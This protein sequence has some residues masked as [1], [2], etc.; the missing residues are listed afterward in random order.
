MGQRSKISSQRTRL[1]LAAA[2]APLVAMPAGARAAEEFAVSTS[3]ATALGAFT[4]GNTEANAPTSSTLYR[5]PLAVGTNFTL[6]TTSYTVP[7]SGIQYYGIANLNSVLTSEPTTSQDRINYY[8]RESGSIQGILDLVDSNGL[9]NASG[10]A[11]VLPG[12]PAA[13]LFVWQ[14]GSRFTAPDSVGTPNT[15]RSIGHNY[16]T[17]GTFN[18]APGQPLVRV[19]WSDVRFEQGFSLSGSAT[20]DKKPTEA[21]YGLGQGN[22]GGTNFQQLRNS[23]AIIGG[24]N[25]ST[26]R[27]RNE[28]LAVVPFNLVAN[29]GTG[30]AKVTKEEGKWLQATGRLQNGANFN[31]ITREIGS[32]T[33]NQGDNNLGLDP[34]WGGGE[35]DRRALAS[36]TTTD[37]NGNP[38]T[39]N[40]G[41]EADPVRS[42]TGTTSQDPNENRIGPTAR[43]SD[44]I[45][46][47]SGVR[48]TVV[49]SRM[50]I[51]ILSAGDSRSNGSG[52]ALATHST[53]G[54]PMRALKIDWGN[55]H[56]YLAATAQNVT[57]G[58]YEMWS[59]SQ[60][61][62]VAPYANPDSLEK[63][64]LDASGNPTDL[65]T[66]TPNPN[67]DSAKAYRPVNGDTNDQAIGSPTST[68]QQG[69][70]RKFLDNITKSV[71]T[72]TG[73]NPE[74][75]PADFII[76]SSFIPPQIMKVTKQFDGGATTP[77]TLSDVDPDGAGPGVSEQTLWN[78]TV[79][80][81]GEVLFDQTNWANPSTFNGG[82]SAPDAPSAVKYRIF[83][84]ANNAVSGATA[85]RTIDVTTR[86][87]LA[88]DF[89]G[90]A[91]R[92]LGDVPAMALAFA[93]P[94]TYLATPASGSTI[95]RNYNGTQVGSTSTGTNASTAD[96]LIVLSDFNSNGNVAVD[97][98]NSTFAT[99]AVEKADVRYFLYGA[100]VDTVNGNAQTGYLGSAD[101]QTRREDGVRLG[102]LKKNAAIDTFN[103]TLDTFVD[104]TTNQTAGTAISGYTQFQANAQKFNKFD[105]NNDG[106][107]NRLDAAYVD[108]NVGK[109]YTVLV[110]VLSTRDDLVAAELNDTGDITHILAD[111]ESDFQ[112]IRLALGTSSLLDG[113]TDFDGTVDFTDL[114]N[115][116][117]SYNSSGN[118]WS[119]GDTDFNGLVDFTDLGNLLN[120]YNQSAIL[121]FTIDATVFGLDVQAVSLL[122]DEGFTVVPEPST[123]GVIGCVVGAGVLSRRR[124]ARAS[125]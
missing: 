106:L 17:P 58:K 94:S 77:R 122:R 8:Y 32:G 49:A 54:A 43:F 11:S 107:V 28:S 69:V 111:G 30:L 90:D 84:S 61:V 112:L 121:G 103:A 52:T 81:S 110:D 48:A 51:G 10:G 44:K 83:A 46:G 33:R 91:V 66:G 115:L 93:S 80:N 56:G 36:Y 113:D 60:A 5:G 119:T 29:P 97:A 37:I 114:G 117:N 72:F 25:A 108:R 45:S 68:A 62:T 14:N 82:I 38:I 18:G 6:G 64:F 99:T 35:R 63:Q 105:V 104:N 41:D 100:T 95:G 31:S 87:N 109:S 55:G 47:S 40:V 4:R 116:L 96:G 124:K 21:G 85:N 78:N 101:A 73:V 75:T 9:L 65:N 12:D 20:H 50:G 3:G 125:Q 27:L 67:Y 57:E 86:T 53:T 92:D 24:I 19:A 59:A 79:D 123:F 42:L 7:A 102:Q 71:T 13:N 22:I 120:V 2:V 89:N 15:G 23:S 16:P 34:S 76:G 1:L 118:K 39:V 26:T 88:G 74:I 98:N 70:H